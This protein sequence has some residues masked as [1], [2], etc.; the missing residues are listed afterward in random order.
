MQHL[1]QGRIKLNHEMMGGHFPIDTEGSR[2]V[3]TGIEIDPLFDL[4]LCGFW[5]WGWC[6][7]ASMHK[8][9]ARCLY[10]RFTLTAWQSLNRKTT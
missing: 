9:G 7:P 8:P 5:P 6:A 3:E 10:S 1:I 4:G 2:G